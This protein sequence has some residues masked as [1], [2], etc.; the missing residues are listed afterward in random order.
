[1]NASNPFTAELQRRAEARV[2]HLSPEQRMERRL[3]AFQL[4]VVRNDGKLEQIRKLHPAL[5][6]QLDAMQSAHEEAKRK[7]FEERARHAAEQQQNPTSESLL[8]SEGPS[9]AEQPNY[10]S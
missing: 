1:M 6:D 2:A 10:Y 8:E 3:R 7:A 5:A 9:V 4:L